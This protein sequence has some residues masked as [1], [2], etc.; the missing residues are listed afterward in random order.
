MHGLIH[1]ILKDLVVSH[2]GCDAKWAEV[3]AEL[4]AE[5]DASLLE[6]KQYPDDISV[7]C[8]AATAKCLGVSVADALRA[9]GGH[10]VDYVFC[11][12]H[13][14]MLSTMGNTTLKF[15][16]NVNHMHSILE[17]QMRSSHFPLF[18]IDDIAEDSSSNTGTF[19]LSYS[20]HRGPLL[21]PLIEGALPRLGAKLHGQLVKVLRVET[22]DGYD[23]SF[24]VT[25]EALPETC[26][27]EHAEP[28]PG[29][30][31][32]HA[33]LT[34]SDP[35]DEPA[36]LRSRMSSLDEMMSR[37]HALPE[38]VLNELNDL[39]MQ[40]GKLVDPA[41]VLMRGVPA[42]QVAAEWTDLKKLK[43]VRDFWATNAGDWS[44]WKRATVKGR[45]NRF[46]SHSWSPPGNWHK[47]MGDKSD[48]FEVKAT[49]I[50]V[51]AMDLAQ[52]GQDWKNDVSLWVRC[53]YTAEVGPVAVD[54][55]SRLAPQVDKCCI[56]QTHA[57]MP[58]CVGLLE[59]FIRRSDGM[60]V[61]L[62]W[63]YFERLW[64]ER[65]ESS[66]HDGLMH[67]RRNS[68]VRAVHAV[69]LRVGRIP[70]PPQ[71]DGHQHLCGGLHA[72][73]NGANLCRFHR[74]ALREELRVLQRGRPR[75][76]PHQGACARSV[77][78]SGWT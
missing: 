77:R 37:A 35:V 58:T 29:A 5:D 2:F 14:R 44:D 54:S 70:D 25:M 48:Y 30:A 74:E 62:S 22:R 16:C 45:A 34:S 28:R 69:R 36:S 31:H 56:P 61:L 60:I 9:F 12:S 21:A 8:I 15:M 68:P 46:V 73:R 11:G 41:S 33:A 55:A 53:P 13:Q 51:I 39:Q 20:S 78:R 76:A 24:H 42:G 38:D 64:V 6:L 65:C 7:A 66:P 17:R 3:V 10:F 47:I 1:V 75:D 23:A 57:L 49:E 63:H 18:A 19:S 4:K 52:N 71:A 32:W 67:P 26:P 43:S 27:A 72:T 40:V 50:A 59:E